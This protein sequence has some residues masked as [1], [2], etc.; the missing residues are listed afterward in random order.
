MG[1]DG[2]F[3][4]GLNMAGANEY[5][6]AIQVMISLFVILFAAWM[7]YPRYWLNR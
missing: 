3:L 7:L 5:L 2:D 6:L 1:I 4:Y